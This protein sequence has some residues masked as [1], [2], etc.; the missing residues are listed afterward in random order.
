MTG[1]IFFLQ[2][3]LI[4]GKTRVKSS[5]EEA[6]A[7]MIAATTDSFRRLFHMIG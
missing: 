2:L 7:L 1:N 4:R 6:R 5:K 3:H